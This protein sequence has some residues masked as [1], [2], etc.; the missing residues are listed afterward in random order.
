MA[1]YVGVS[2][3]NY[4]H[5]TDPVMVRAIAGWYGLQMD[6]SPTSDGWSLQPEQY[7]DHDI[8]YWV[9]ADISEEDWEKVKEL[10]IIPKSAKRGQEDLEFKDFFKAIAK[11]IPE[12][13]VFIWMHIGSQRLQYLNGYSVA[14]NSKG[15]IRRIQLDH[16]YKLAEGLGDPAKITQAEY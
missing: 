9:P 8:Q 12:G 6:R 4:V 1:D 5:F 2:R 13:E 3:S 16:I 14:V 15:Q 11:Y 7:R 10:G